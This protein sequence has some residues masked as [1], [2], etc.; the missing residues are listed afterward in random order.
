MAPTTS[1]ISAVSGYVR[2]TSTHLSGRQALARWGKTGPSLGQFRTLAELTSCCRDAV[3]AHQDSLLLALL[4]AAND[5]QLAQL[6]VLACLSR[7]LCAVVAGWRRAGAS[8]DD[9]RAMEADL[10]SEA[11]LAVARTAALLAGGGRPP[12]RVGLVLV[13]QARHAVRAHRRRELR[14]TGREVALEH[15]NGFGQEPERPPGEQLAAEIGAA[16]R[17]GRISARL[18]APV[19]LTRVAGYSPEE[20]AKRLG[21]K[22]SVLR[23]LRSRAERRLVA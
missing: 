14:A 18:A 12:A 3:P 15:F 2:A 9:L 23:A 8:A 17:A 6:T 20:A 5:D 1:L 4:A 21:M 16:V 19:L 22:A 13:D 11:W 7:K 10:V